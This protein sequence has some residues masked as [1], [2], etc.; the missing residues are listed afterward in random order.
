MRSLRQDEPLV[1]QEPIVRRSL[2]QNEPL[3]RQ[4]E[5]SVRRSLHCAGMEG[6]VEFDK[7]GNKK[8]KEEMTER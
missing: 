5:P 6:P 1:R 3:V 7:I 8:I 4:K 2:R